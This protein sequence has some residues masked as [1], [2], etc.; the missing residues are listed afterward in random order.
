M[1]RRSGIPGEGLRGRPVITD[2]KWCSIYISDFTHQMNIKITTFSVHFS[3]PSLTLFIRTSLF[4]SYWHKVRSLQDI[5]V[6]QL[7]L[8]DS[9]GAPSWSHGRSAPLQL[10]AALL[11]SSSLCVCGIGSLSFFHCLIQHI[12]IH[13]CEIPDRTVSAKMLIFQDSRIKVELSHIPLQYSE[14]LVPQVTRG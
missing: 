14:M 11:F 10:A 9:L 4:V 3:E 7:A 2:N 5:T 6:L 13:Y 1:W 12:L 8:R